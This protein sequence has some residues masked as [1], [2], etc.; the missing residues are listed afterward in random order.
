MASNYISAD[1]TLARAKAYIRLQ[2]GSLSQQESQILDTQLTDLVH[3]SI[4]S[5][6]TLLD[7]IVEEYYKAIQT[8]TFGAAS[9]GL[10]AGTP[11][12]GTARPYDLKKIS[13]YDTT[14]LEIPIYSKSMFDAMRT[15]LS[16][17]DLGTTGAIAGI[18]SISTGTVEI[19]AYVGNAAPAAASLTYIRPVIKQTDEAY[20]LDMPDRWMPS[21]LDH[22]VL[23]V[24][25][26]LAK[27][28]PEN[29][30]KQVRENVGH[31]ASLLNVDMGS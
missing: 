31:I 27:S 30:E 6:R 14:Y 9:S 11:L 4:L 15:V 24:F 21:V 3:Q 2:T 28:P 29:I 13:L 23:Q 20:T 18:Y 8:I 12:T 5:M 17:S 16:T 19:D 26:R 10:C 7:R 25:R 1:W 22:C